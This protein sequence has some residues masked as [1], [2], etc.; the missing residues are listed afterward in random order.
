[1]P[2]EYMY[3]TEQIRR[4]VPLATW[5]SVV[6]VPPCRVSDVP[7]GVTWVLCISSER[8]LISLRW[9]STIDATY[10]LATVAP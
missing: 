1:M 8:T 6:V 3:V 2:R 10:L 9:N 5:M 4:E 7:G